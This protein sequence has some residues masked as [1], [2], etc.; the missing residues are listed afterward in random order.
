MIRRLIAKPEFGPFVLLVVELIVF[1][2]L[3]PS[4]LSPQNISNTLVFTV[5]LGLIALAMTLLMTSGEF[6]L[7]V[8][9]MF[10]FAP[11]GMWALLNSRTNRLD[12]GF[13]VRLR[14]VGDVDAVQFRHHLAGGWVPRSARGRGGGRLRQRLVRDAAQ[15][16]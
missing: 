12:A 6:D 4:F 15:N 13:A 11:V 3:N 8:G 1:T 10:G 16:P 14:P 2:A 5:E 7:S 9:S